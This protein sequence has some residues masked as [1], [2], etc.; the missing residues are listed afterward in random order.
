MKCKL[1]LVGAKGNM[2][3][4][5]AAI[6]KSFFPETSVIGV[7]IGDPWPLSFD[8]AIVATPTETHYNICLKLAASRKPFLCEKPVVKTLP[9]METLVQ[10]CSMGYMVNNWAHV[11]PDWYLKPNDSIIDY[12]F[13]HTGHDGLHWDCIQ[14]HYL[15]KEIKINNESPYFRASINGEEVTLEMIE[16]SYT[17]MLSFFLKDDERWLWTMQDALN[18]TRKVSALISGHDPD[19]PTYFAENLESEDFSRTLEYDRL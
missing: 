18:A 4:R 6:L 13:Y 12:D 19:C 7:D 1:L 5:Y 8:K 2:G 3:R 16:A 15:A 9:Q 14:L 11:F 10:N 17:K